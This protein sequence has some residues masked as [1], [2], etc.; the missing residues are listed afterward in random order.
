MIKQDKE[1]LI[2]KSR[3]NR[4]FSVYYKMVTFSSNYSLGKLFPVANISISVSVVFPN[5]PAV[6]IKQ[7]CSL[8]FSRLTCVVRVS[9]CLSSAVQVLVGALFLSRFISSF[10]EHLFRCL[11]QLLTDDSPCMIDHR[12][13]GRNLPRRLPLH[14][15]WISNGTVGEIGLDPD[16]ERLLHS[17][18]YFV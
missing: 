2:W 18:I 12:N 14:F 5:P 9:V 4:Q 17:A 10:S 15:E 1:K 11:F 16:Q 3:R 13:L 8:V 7:G 6:K